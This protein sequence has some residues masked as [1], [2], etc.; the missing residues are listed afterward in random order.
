MTTRF[1]FL[2]IDDDAKRIDDY[3]ATIEGGVPGR[4]WTSRIEPLVVTKRLLEQLNERLES[5]KPRPDLIIIDHVFTKLNN[6]LKLKGSSVAS[7]LRGAWP[8]IPMVC[9]TAMFTKG[10]ST[11]DQQD[12]SEYTA[13]FEY[14]H[15]DNHL[16]DLFLIAKDFPKLKVKSSDLRDDVISTLKAPKGDRDGLKHV[17]PE[18][19]RTQLHGTTRH[20]VARWIF[21]TLMK[22]PG[23]L[24]NKLRAA[25]YLGLTEIGFE[26][27]SKIFER[28]RYAGP[29]ASDKRPLWW[30]S[31]LSKLMYANVSDDAPDIPQLAG[32][33][34]QGIRSNHYSVCYVTRSSVQFPDAVAS[35]DSRS[36]IERAVHSRYTAVDLTDVGVPAGFEQRL[37]IARKSK[38]K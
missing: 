16:E 28:A 7:L 2:W 20:R 17:L 4:P 15:L 30:A 9:V 5:S 12:L 21:N 1:K 6:P 3:R 11:F 38:R 10:G 37:V 31:E 26:K 23:F 34:L 33:K 8:D 14:P 36:P 25:T 32:R 13:V 27:V 18:E 35:V 24:Y 19:F 22:R 29:F